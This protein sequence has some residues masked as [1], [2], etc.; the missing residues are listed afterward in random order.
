VSLVLDEHRT[1]L[2]DGVRLAAFEK[3]IA[4]TVKPGD[5]VIDL[6]SGTGILGLLALRAG[7]ARVYALEETSLGGLAREIAAANGVADRIHVMRGLSTWLTLPE[8]ADVVI[9]DQIGPF[10]IEAGIFEY[11]PDARRRLL[12]PDGR[13]IPRALS[14]RCAPVECEPLRRSIDFWRHPH[15]GFDLAAVVPPAE[16]SGYPITLD[17]EVL[18]ATAA[19]VA[20]AAVDVLPQS[21]LVS[22]ETTFTITRAGTFDGLG[23]W[24][25]ADLAAGVTF[26]NGP[27]SAERIN[28]R[29]VV[30]PVAPVHVTPGD[31]AHVRLRFRPQTLMVDW[32]VRVAGVHGT[33][34]MRV[35]RS[36][37]QGMLI[38]PEDLTRKAPDARPS[39][40]RRGQA[41]RTVLELCD[42]SRSVA[43]IETELRAAFP[44]LLASDDDAAAFVSDVLGSDAS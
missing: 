37:F 26:T 21:G 40:S 25:V 22:G 11:L 14:W 24:F 3:A 1:Y 44:D 30:L 19:T 10:G 29:Q 36:T 2:A 27:D 18:L 23:G 28:R 12:K 32:Q 39:L 8:L 17:P 15:T 38:A 20:T 9:T 7:A 34:R 42:G 43:E 6:G 16:G 33:E 13:T 35:R 41:R 5:I 31:R 4:A